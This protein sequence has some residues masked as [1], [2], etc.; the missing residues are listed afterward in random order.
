MIALPEEPRRADG[1]LSEQPTD[2]PVP[3]PR[4]Q[5]SHPVPSVGTWVG[6]KEEPARFE[7]LEQVG[8]GAEGSIHRARYV[9]RGGSHELVAVKRYRRSPQA[10]TDASGDDAWQ[11]V[12]DQAW[13]LS[14]LPRSDHLVHV[15]QVFRGQVVSSGRPDPEG[16]VPIVV[17]DWIDGEPPGTLLRRDPVE[18]P[19]RLGWIRDLAEAVEL[20]HTVSRADR[21]PLVHA[22]IK[23]GNCLIAPGRGLVLV[24]TGT[25]QRAGGDGDLRGLRTLRYA[26]PEVLRDPGRQRQPESDL[27]A[28]AAVAFQF[29]TLQQPPDSGADGYLDKAVQTIL[30]SDALPDSDRPRVAAHLA[31]LLDPEPAHRYAGGTVAWARELTLLLDPAP[32]SAPVS[33]PLRRRMKIGIGVAAGV[34]A[35]VGGLGLRA[36]SP[37]DEPTVTSAP[38][39][40]ASATGAPASTGPDPAPADA[41][42][43]LDF[44]DLPAFDVTSGPV[45]YSQ[46]LATPSAAWPAT[47]AAGYTTRYSDAG[48]ELELTSTGEFEPATAPR[49]PSVSD[50]LV[51]ATATTIAGQ[52]GWG[53]WC[54]GTD[55]AG[56]RRYE[57]LISHTGAVQIIEPGDTG[58]GWIYLRGL[59]LSQP[60]T[61]TAHCADVIG[62]PIE[63]TLVVNGRVAL[64]YRPSITLGPG[65]AGIEGMTFADVEGPK[66]T[67]AYRRFTIARAI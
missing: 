43:T 4:R 18:L 38:S 54:R 34:L 6:P 27:Y 16:V 32:L 28:F 44:A 51:T 37:T 41:A 42:P 53:V 62:A 15:R 25:V 56:S 33:A 52:G 13:H 59:D 11:R 26:A 22:D 35:I 7:L 67:A 3:A 39:A 31:A 50:Q 61:L 64:T 24:D 20:L 14:R 55:Q 2:V 21:D 23:P 58:T 45:L 48:Y 36:L 1:E 40:A 8:S 60:V 5:R 49:T 63:L 9:G 19:V 10:G 17:M 47:T 65:Y 66:I 30:C 46:D 29:L 12:N 57:F